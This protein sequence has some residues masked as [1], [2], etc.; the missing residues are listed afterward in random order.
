VNVVVT[1][2]APATADANL[3]ERSCPGATSPSVIG[4][5]AAD[6]VAAAADVAAD[7]AAATAACAADR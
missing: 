6:A 3:T 4:T 7:V 2:L 1:V 5:V